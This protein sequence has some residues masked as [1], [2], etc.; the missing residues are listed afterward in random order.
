MV[1]GGVG[2][3]KGWFLGWDDVAPASRG[4][5]QL[6]PRSVVGHQESSAGA[7]GQQGGGG[8]LG[9]RGK[10]VSGTWQW[11]KELMQLDGGKTTHTARH[12]KWDFNISLYG[13][14]IPKN[15]VVL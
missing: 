15:F 13:M 9:K 1:L 8:H 12:K 11:S 6:G 5:F 2:E 3:G 10:R 14:S 7:A 4:C